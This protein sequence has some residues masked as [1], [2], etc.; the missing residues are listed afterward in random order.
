VNQINN[1]HNA[2]DIT[3]LLVNP[4]FLLNSALSRTDKANTTSI[5]IN[6]NRKLTTSEDIITAKIKMFALVVKNTWNLVK[7]FRMMAMIND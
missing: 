4:I 1:A 5:Q 2:K 3:V 6:I 7:C